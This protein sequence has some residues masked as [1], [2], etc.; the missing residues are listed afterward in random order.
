MKTILNRTAGP[1]KVPLPGGRLLHLGPGK[2]GQVSDDAFEHA[3]LSE[4]LEAGDIEIVDDDSGR[5]GGPH[6]G[7]GHGGD[8][9]HHPTAVIRPKG[10]R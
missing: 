10:D 8:R 4:M 9:G 3:T 1:L 2:T 7:H 6:G 5:R